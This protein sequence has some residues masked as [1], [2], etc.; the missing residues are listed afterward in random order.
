MK[1]FYSF[2]LQFY[3]RR[4]YLYINLAWVGVCLFVS[5]KRQ[6]GWSDLAQILCGTSHDPR[7]GLRMIKIF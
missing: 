4:F 1:T 5:N 2:F 3:V 7:E 6:N